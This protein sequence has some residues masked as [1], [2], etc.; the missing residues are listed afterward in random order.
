MSDHI[1]II[2]KT[3]RDLLVSTVTRL[4]TQTD[5]LEKIEKHLKD[6][7]GTVARNDTRSRNNR[8]AVWVVISAIITAAITNICGVW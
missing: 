5:V 7:N 8:T 4:N 3:N 2:K 6:Q 1:E